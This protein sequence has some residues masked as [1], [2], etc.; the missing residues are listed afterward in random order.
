MS[1]ASSGDETQV[2]EQGSLRAPL[3]PALEVGASI[4]RYVLIE[5]VGRGGMGVVYS[6]YDPQLDRKVAVKLLAPTGGG[7]PTPAAESLLSEA[8]ALARVS[9]PNVVAIHDVG[10]E[11]GRVFLAMDFVEGVTLAAWCS[12]GERSVREILDVFVQAGHGLAAAHQRGL[13]HRDFKPDNVMIGADGPISVPRAQVMDFGLAQRIRSVNELAEVDDASTAQTGGALAGTPRFMAPEQFA[14]AELT[15]QTDQFSFCVALWSALFGQHPFGG[16]TLA[17]LA[18]NVTAGEL[19]EP[20]NIKVGAHVRAALRRGL[21]LRPEQRWPDMG[22]LLLELSRD[23]SRTRRRVGLV[24]GGA[25]LVGGLVG[26]E[27]LLHARAVE[28]CEREGASIDEVWN[29]EAR[30]RTSEGLLATGLP[31]ARDTVE[32][33]EPWLDRTAKGWAEARTAACVVTQIEGRWDRERAEVSAVCL[34]E[35]RQRFAATIEV[36]AEADAGIVDGAVAMTSALPLLDS[37]VDERYLDHLPVELGDPQQ[38]AQ[39]RALEAALAKAQGDLLAGRREAARETLER[40]QADAGAIDF[41]RGVVRAGQMLARID[42]LE[43]RY[44]QAEQGYRRVFVLAMEG[45]SVHLASVLAA[46]L[47]TVIGVRQRAAAKGAWWIEL[48]L[49]LARRSGVKDDDPQIFQAKHMLAKLS[50]DDGRFDDALRLAEQASAAGEASLGAR[51][52]GMAEVAATLASIHR[53]RGDYDEAVDL[54]RQGVERLGAALGVEHPKM[55]GALG[56]L[57]ENLR[58]VGAIEEAAEIQRRGLAVAR[59]SFPPG[60]PAVAAARMSVALMLHEQGR[61]ADARPMI[62][63][64]VA[65]VEKA[66]GREHVDLMPML[67]NLGM[68]YDVLGDAEGAAGAYGRALAI[69]DASLPPEHPVRGILLSNLGTAELSM[70]DFEAALGHH[71]EAMALLEQTHG[72]EHPHLV[73]AHANLAQALAGLGRHAE[74]LA[75]AKRSSAVATAVHEPDHLDV[76]YGLVGIAA[77]QLAL[78]DAAAAIE[79]ATRA[80]RIRSARVGVPELRAEAEWTLAQALARG[81]G[82]RA[83]ANELA[84]AAETFYATGDPEVRAKIEAFLAQ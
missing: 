16:D 50:R 55:V 12:R 72:A 23:P 79:P 10:I 14:E 80:L 30:R 43:Q 26:G 40:T 29:D 1:H 76:S 61:S 57:A 15:A 32:R 58:R 47:A 24:I 83:R 37:C 9:H 53:E 74:S 71:R 31:R 51:H 77:A 6:A 3:E 36:L 13:V 60:H 7:T 21:A 54:A 48:S 66:L 59:K 39:R 27:R 2:G 78:G 38:G 20:T 46:D 82:D 56:G 84:T 81:G 64:S 62:E 19:R 63:R 35:R 33:I 65:E 75:A 28:A 4:G 52:P 45:G 17:E 67:S 18:A 25:A 5:R 49:A 22:A 42:E 73:I 68:V 8:Q 44:E 34:E 70:G 41:G 69:V 11:R